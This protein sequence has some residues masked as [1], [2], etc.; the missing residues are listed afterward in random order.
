[1][2]M[3]AAN[4]DPIG[5]V[6]ALTLRITGFTQNMQP[7]TTRQI[8][9][10]SKSTDK[11]FLSMEACRDLGIIPQ[12]FPSIES[13]MT[14]SSALHSDT[15]NNLDEDCCRCPLRQSPPPLP[16]SLPFPATEENREKLEQWLLDYYKS[17]TFN[18]CEHQKLPMMSGPPMR[19]IVDDDA[20]P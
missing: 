13:A 7:K 2:K 14:D 8:V 19:L 10:I 6:G 17:S 16:T 5:I 18:V 20:T 15:D 9:Y 4:Q 1:M 11:F 3:K 12:S